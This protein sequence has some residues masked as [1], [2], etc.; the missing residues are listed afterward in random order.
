MLNPLEKLQNWIIQELNNSTLIAQSA[1]LSTVS[2]QSQPRA[3]VVSTM[4]DAALIPKFHTSSVSRKSQDIKHNNAVTLT[5]NFHNDLFV[6]KV[7]S[8]LYPS[9]N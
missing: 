7:K 9:N 4:F 5:Y 8:N 6:S 2:E 1:V 3:R